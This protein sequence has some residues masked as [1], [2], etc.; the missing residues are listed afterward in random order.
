L[1]LRAAI[2]PAHLSAAATKEIHAL[3]PD[4]PVSDIRMLEGGRGEIHRATALQYRYPP[5]F[6]PVSHL[7]WR[8]SEF[9]E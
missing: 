3:D 6:S 9:T 1:V 7:S 8:R 4:Q 2:D 5:R